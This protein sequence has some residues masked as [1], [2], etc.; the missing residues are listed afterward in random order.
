MRDAVGSHQVVANAKFECGRRSVSCLFATDAN[1]VS[2]PAFEQLDR[3]LRS[4]RYRAVMA[5]HRYAD[6][7]YGRLHISNVSLAKG[8]RNNT[9]A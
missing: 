7:L 6:P 3:R 4:H 8:T 5:D 2:H 9:F 1:D